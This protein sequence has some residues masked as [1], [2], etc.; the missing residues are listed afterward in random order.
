MDDDKKFIKK[1]QT[2]I[3]SETIQNL[4]IGDKIEIYGTIFTGRDAALPKLVES[5]KN[6]E[7]LLDI[8]GAVFMASFET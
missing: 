2:P 6:G 5:I 4:K 7:N 3:T 1:I 8:E